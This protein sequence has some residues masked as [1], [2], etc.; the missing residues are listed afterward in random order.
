MWKIYLIAVL[1]FSGCTKFTIS[2]AMCDQIASDPQATIPKECRN[3]N[4]K[5]A[6]KSFNKTKK[7]QSPEDI[8][9]FNKE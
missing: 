7:K 6:E 1:L 5:E 8:I 2:A 4:E 9:E 3:Y